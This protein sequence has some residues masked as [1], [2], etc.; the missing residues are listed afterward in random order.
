[1]LDVKI[2]LNFLL[3]QQKLLALLEVSLQCAS[4]GQLVSFVLA[5]AE[6]MLQN[7]SLKWIKFSLSC[8][9]NVANRSF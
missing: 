2:K 8:F 5:L 4:V 3:T 7:Y 9:I 1:M 6:G